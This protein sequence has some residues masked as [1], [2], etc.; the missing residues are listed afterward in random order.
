[1]NKMLK[2]VFAKSAKVIQNPYTLLIISFDSFCSLIKKID[3]ISKKTSMKCFIQ[4]GY[5]HLYKWLE[6]ELLDVISR[7][8]SVHF[9]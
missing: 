8:N 5:K 1:M 7:Q 6:N 2:N 3:S 9:D 4:V